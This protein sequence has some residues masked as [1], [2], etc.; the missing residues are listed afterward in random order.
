M[1]Q[2]TRQ[3]LRPLRPQAYRSFARRLRW[4]AERIE[5]YAEER[6]PREKA[7]L[8]RVLHSLARAL[9]HLLDRR[10][11]RELPAATPEE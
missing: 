7:S 10:R 3:I 1:T 11:G 5:R 4:A 6:D 2:F 8:T 9:R